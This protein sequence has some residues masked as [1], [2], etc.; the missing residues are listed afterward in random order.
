MEF[1]RKMDVCFFS[2]INC[3]SKFERLL[4]DYSILITL[5]NAGIEITFRSPCHGVAETNP[6]GKD[7]FAG[8]IPGLSQWVKD[9]ELL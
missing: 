6:T 7:E 5:T 9:P 2:E 1:N 3:C 8:S 4:L